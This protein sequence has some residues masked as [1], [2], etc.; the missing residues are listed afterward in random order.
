MRV[1]DLTFPYWTTKCEVTCK[2]DIRLE[3]IKNSEGG[4]ERE[5]EGGKVE[6]E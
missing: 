5:R 3:C 4:R 2:V 6:E 1:W